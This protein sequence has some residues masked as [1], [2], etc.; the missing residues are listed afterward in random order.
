MIGASKLNEKDVEVIK[1]L[2]QR[3]QM[4]DTEIGNAF[5]VSRVHINRIRH[6]KRWNEETKSFKMKQHQPKWWNEYI[7]EYIE[8]KIQDMLDDELYY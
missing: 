6:G 3:T 5:G 8:N 1:Y 4:T 2:F 7:E